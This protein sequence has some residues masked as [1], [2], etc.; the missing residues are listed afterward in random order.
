MGLLLLVTALVS[1]VP[2]SIHICNDVRLLHA[3]HRLCHPP[4][5]RGNANN[6]LFR[7]TVR[8][9]VRA[10]SSLDVNVDDVSDL[11]I[12]YNIV[13]FYKYQNATGL[14]PFPASNGPFIEMAMLS[15]TRPTNRHRFSSESFL[16]IEDDLFIGSTC[17]AA[18][19]TA[20]SVLFKNYTAFHLSVEANSSLAFPLAVLFGTGFYYIQYT[21]LDFSRR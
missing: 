19:V 8:K 16:V 9:A 11:L 1:A 6:F 2:V 17:S 13:A 21:L 7:L 14:C 3:L 12:T 18:N 4:R 10:P 5:S 15:P 20:C